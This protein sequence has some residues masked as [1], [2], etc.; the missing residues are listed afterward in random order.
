LS[1]ERATSLDV[2]ESGWAQS[3][4]VADDPTMGTSGGGWRERWD[5]KEG[6]A[7]LLSTSCAPWLQKAE[8]LHGGF[9]M[10]CDYLGT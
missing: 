10:S 8:E 4:G 2:A 7:V 6:P 3:L 9:N 1:S 5:R